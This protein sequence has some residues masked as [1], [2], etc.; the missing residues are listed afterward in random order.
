MLKVAEL[1]RRWLK[2]GYAEE[3]EVAVEFEKKEEVVVGM[4]KVQKGGWRWDPR[5]DDDHSLAKK[6]LKPRHTQS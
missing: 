4:G 3:E 6:N 2:V 1:H 5:D